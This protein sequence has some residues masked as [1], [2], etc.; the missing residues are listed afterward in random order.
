MDITIFP[1]ALSGTVPAIPSKS[2]AHRLMICAAFADKPTTLLCRDT[3]QDI[4]ATAQCLR[5][6]GAEITRTDEGYRIL[7][8]QQPPRTAT[9][10]CA[11]SGST[12]R[13]LLPV[14]G[15]LGVDA[16]FR[17]EGR[18][19]QRPLSP[20]WEEMERM[21]CRLSHPEKNTIR[22]EGK[23]R[24]GEYTIDGG[25]SSQYITG[26]ML[27]L[28][29]LEDK[30]QLHITGKLESAPYV[31]MTQKALAQFSVDWNS[32]GGQCFHSPG[33]LQVEGDW[34]NAAFF[35]AAKHLGQAV[36]VSGLSSDSPQGDKAVCKL[37]SLLSVKQVSISA[38]DIPDLVPILAVFATANHGAVFTDIG[39][40]RLKESDRVAS[41]V[42]MLQDLGG[43]AEATDNT[44]TIYP[45]PLAGGTVDSC[46]DHRI[47][48]A[49]AIAS[50]V[51][52]NPVTIL[53]AN[54]VNKSYPGFWAEYRRLGGK[55]EQFLR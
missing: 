33:T 53:D 32:L 43:R 3:N 16:A 6:L 45:Q 37:L 1:H 50:T 52:K 23:L 38:A 10:P 9:L 34:S 11:E 55:Y 40:L 54:S 39:R 36:E 8:I 29:L 26:L 44:L 4:E 47:A 13:F 18:L 48:M 7:P 41:V 5:A 42:S 22:C 25:V 21:G 12:L 20:L 30:S 15:A 2:H 17:M 14:A 49:A 24:A 28:S 46:N 27:G 35:L 51:C 31:C 19:S